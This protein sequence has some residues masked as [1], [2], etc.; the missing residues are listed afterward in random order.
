MVK[1]DICNQVKNELESVLTTINA[2]VNTSS[3]SSTNSL[4]NEVIDID[5]YI[6][7]VNSPAAKSDDS[8][9]STNMSDNA[10]GSYLGETKTNKK[11]DKQ[12]RKSSTSS[13]STSTL[14]NAQSYVGQYNSYLE[15]YEDFNSH[16]I[17]EFRKTDCY[18]EWYEL[19]RAK[20]EKSLFKYDPVSQQ[21]NHSVNNQ[22]NEN[23]LQQANLNQSNSNDSISLNNRLQLLLSQLQ[24]LERIRLNHPFNGQINVNDLK[25]RLNLLFTTTESG[26]KINKAFTEGSK[27]VNNTGKVVG[28]ALK[29]TFNSFLSNWSSPSA[30]N[31]NQSTSSTSNSIVL[32]KQGDM[33]PNKPATKM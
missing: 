17:N 2:E 29:S 21:F 28:D 19:N 13:S 9:A 5:D 11:H 10:N 12:N 27:L 20:L 30:S 31:S 4:N 6:E 23:S 8:M 16:F 14:S 32:S 33:T 15:Y 25:L 24:E 18:K 7:K 1:E 3:C 26:K 22:T